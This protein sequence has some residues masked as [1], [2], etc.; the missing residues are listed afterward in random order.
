M[1]TI[2]RWSGRF[3]RFSLIVLM[4]IVS[5]V[6]AQNSSDGSNDSNTSCRCSLHEGGCASAFAGEFGQQSGGT[7]AQLL[8]QGRQIQVNKVHVFPKTLEA[9]KREQNDVRE[10][11]KIA[12]AKEES[13]AYT[14]FKKEV[15][16]LSTK[17][18]ISHPPVP[19]NKSIR[20]VSPVFFCSLCFLW[21]DTFYKAS[22]PYSTRPT[23]W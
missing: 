3:V 7:L 17:L 14:P 22:E 19:Q 23:S 5:K 4:T 1:Q 9:W 16:Y 20:V 6:H 12:N 10:E 8:A 11:E 13:V 2:K 15:A 21:S 18:R